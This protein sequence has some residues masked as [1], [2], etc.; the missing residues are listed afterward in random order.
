[1]SRLL[2]LQEEMERE[3]ETAIREVT[4]EKARLTEAYQ[5]EIAKLDALLAKIAP[6]MLAP[7][8]VTPVVSGLPPRTRSRAEAFAMAQGRTETSAKW[9]GQKFCPYCQI[10][11]H[12]GRAHRGQP[13]PG[14]WSKAELAAFGYMPPAGQPQLPANYDQIPQVKTHLG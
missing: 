8:P 3:K 2:A 12:D 11:G 5:A 9:N 13:A 1:M 14:K 10:Q 4:A 7:A 6:E